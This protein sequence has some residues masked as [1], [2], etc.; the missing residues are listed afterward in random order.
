[1]WLQCFYLWWSL[2]EWPGAAVHQILT[3][4]HIFFNAA[5]SDSF[6]LSNLGPHCAAVPC[7]HPVEMS[8]AL[9][10]ARPYLPPR[11]VRHLRMIWHGKL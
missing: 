4:E 10:P 3:G 2:Q 9:L 8:K 11:H 1:M 5:T 7:A 6:Q